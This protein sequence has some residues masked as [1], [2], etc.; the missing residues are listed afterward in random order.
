MPRKSR[1]SKQKR[2]RQVIVGTPTAPARTDQAAAARP[3]QQ[4]GVVDTSALAQFA[5]RYRYA[6]RDI[7]RTFIVAA[8]CVALM[9]GLYFLFE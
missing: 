9:V 7:R 4:T 6:L 1:R 2:R 8:I 5:E 3:R